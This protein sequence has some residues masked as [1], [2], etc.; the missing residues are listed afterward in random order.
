MPICS[1]S[2]I[3]LF[4]GVGKY[5]LRSGS[6]STRVFR[7]TSRILW[8]PLM[9]VYLQTGCMPIGSSS[10]SRID[11]SRTPF[12]VRASFKSLE[13]TLIWSKS[14]KEVYNICLDEDVADAGLSQ[15]LNI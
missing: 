2:L 8:L 7:F 6:T 11:V 4:H 3:E 1:P 13:I 14:I 5:P 9:F 12:K 10:Y 15:Y